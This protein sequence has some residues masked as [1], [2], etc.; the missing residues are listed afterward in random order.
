MLSL[1]ECV[2]KGHQESKHSYRTIT[3]VTKP[4]GSGSVFLCDFCLVTLWGKGWGR[5]DFYGG[6]DAG[7]D[8]EG[9]SDEDRTF[10]EAKKLEE[11]FTLGSFTMVHNCPWF[12]V[13]QKKK[14]VVFFSGSFADRL[15]WI[16]ST[17]CF[18]ATDEELRALRLQDLSDPLAAL[19]GDGDAT[20][21]AT[22]ESSGLN[23]SRIWRSIM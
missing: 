2:T 15:V 18:M 22:E 13:V 5:H 20:T 11:R 8:S 12:F 10:K 14:H 17:G 7:D 1:H 16:C 3:R 21:K 23:F 19:L 9:A 6:E 4:Q